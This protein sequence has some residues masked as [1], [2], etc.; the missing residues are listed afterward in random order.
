MFGCYFPLLKKKM[1]FVYFQIP[2]SLEGWRK[3]ALMHL[4]QFIYIYT[5]NTDTCSEIEIN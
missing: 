3:D 1:V 5:W 2:E 4:P